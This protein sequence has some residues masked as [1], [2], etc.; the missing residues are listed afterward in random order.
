MAIIR[1]Y[2]DEQDWIAASVQAITGSLEQDIRDNDASS[3][4]LSGGSTPY[5]IYQ[6]LGTEPVLW[7]QVSLISVD[8]RFVPADDP[9]Y[10]WAKIV[11]A[12]GEELIARVK[13]TCAF[14]YA[15][16]REE[17]L[18]VVEDCL[19]DRPGIVVL[20]MGTDGHIASLFPGQPFGDNRTVV[21]TTAPD[22]YETQ[23]R[24]SLSADYILSAQK[25]VLLLKGESKANAVDILMDQEYPAEQFPA[26]LILDHP[27]CEIHWLR[28][29]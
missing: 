5:P 16:S 9:E 1:T 26:T 22:S 2:T 28:E 3:L 25:I 24:M 20:G 17:S 13:R 11:S 15:A 29:G 19:P 27:D 6:Q 23:E 10:N 21:A 18:R 8:E 7:E 4:A 14:T 12:L